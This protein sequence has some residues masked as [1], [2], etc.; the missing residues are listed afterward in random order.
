MKASHGEG[1]EASREMEMEA[2]RTS[3]TNLETFPFVRAAQKDGTLN[4]RGAYFAIA[5]GQLHL[6]DDKGVFKPA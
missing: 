6:M 1:P 2:V 5:D 3:I 4:L